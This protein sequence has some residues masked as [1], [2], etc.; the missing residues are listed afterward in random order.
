M[1]LAVHITSAQT[2]DNQFNVLMYQ[3]DTTLNYPYKH[4]DPGYRPRPYAIFN[5]SHSQLMSNY[6]RFMLNIFDSSKNKNI[7]NSNLKIDTSLRILDFDK[8]SLNFKNVNHLTGIDSNGNTLFDYS[9]NNV[10][11]YTSGDTGYNNTPLLLYYNDSSA[12]TSNIILSTYSI[13]KLTNYS[14]GVYFNVSSISGTDTMQIKVQYRDENNTINNIYS[15]KI[16][17][18]GNNYFYVNPLRIKNGTTLSVITIFL[19]SAGSINYDSGLEI[20]KNH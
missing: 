9:S 3:T 10:T 12:Q 14:L 4:P 6:L 20:W 19:N 16:Y 18:I 7:G 2:I 11:F 13:K 15:N 8:N 5:T 1:I 17:S